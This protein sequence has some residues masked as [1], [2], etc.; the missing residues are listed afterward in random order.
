MADTA[1]C[2]TLH[3]MA[4]VVHRRHEAIGKSGHVA[5]A[6]GLAPGVNLL[7]LGKIHSQRLFADHMASRLQRSEDEVLVIDIRRGNRDRVG[8]GRGQ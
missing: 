8:R 5:T 6:R 4:N 2:P 3:Q 7:R 1:Q